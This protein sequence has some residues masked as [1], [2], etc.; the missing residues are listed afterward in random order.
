[1]ACPLAASRF[2]VAGSRRRATLERSAAG[3]N[4]GMGFWFRTMIQTSAERPPRR[5]RLFRRR[6][7]QSQSIQ[8]AVLAITCGE[9]SRT[10]DAGDLPQWADSG[11]T[12]VARESALPAL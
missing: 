8:R 3:W 9:G 4:K 11:P 2:E 5:H 1:M 10:L 12:G 7:L 6:H